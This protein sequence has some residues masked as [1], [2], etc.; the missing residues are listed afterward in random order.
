[1]SLHVPTPLLRLREGD[2]VRLCGLGAAARGLALFSSVKIW[3]GARDGARLSAEI[4]GG[5]GVEGRVQVALALDTHENEAS[6][7]NGRW[8]CS[9]HA[10]TDTS[11]VAVLACEHVAA[12]LT[13]WIRTPDIFRDISPRTPETPPVVVDL[14][15]AA[16][17]AEATAASA[18]QTT[19]PM[20]PSTLSAAVAHMSIDAV[21][22]ALAV[23]EEP[24][25]SAALRSPDS[26]G[27]AR[28]RLLRTL[29]DPATL[30]RCIGRLD[31]SARAVLTIG[32]LHGGTLT[33]ADLE[34]YAAR[35]ALTRGALSPVLGMLE[36]MCLLLPVEGVAGR[37]PAQEQQ[38]HQGQEGRAGLRSAFTGWRI[39]RE[40]L[41]LL[42]RVALLA[43]AAQAALPDDVHV[44]RPG[45]RPLALALA[46]LAAAP[47]PRLSAASPSARSRSTVLTPGD[48][49][50]AQV[51]ERSRMTGVA[52][53]I[54]RL[55]WRVLHRAGQTEAA[56]Q[57]DRLAQ[58]PPDARPAA[59]RAAFALWRAAAVPYEL[60]DLDASSA[61]LCVRL[62]LDAPH[63]SVE[64]LASE[65]AQARQAVVRLI[66]LLSPGIWYDVDAL[67]DLLWRAHPLFLRGRQQTYTLPAW[68]FEQPRE[69]RILRPGTRRDWEQ[70]EGLFFRHLLAGP[71]AWFGILNLARQPGGPARAVRVTAFGATCL[72]ETPLQGAS[73]NVEQDVSPEDVSSLDGGWGVPVL[74]RSGGTLA[75]Q[76]FAA[77]APLLGALARWARGTGVAD[78]RLLYALTAEVAADAFDAGQQFEPFV[79]L[80][81]GSDVAHGPEVA[82]FVGGQ[83]AGWRS[84][85]GNTTIAL[86]WVLLSGA[87]EATLREA[88]A[89][90]PDL[91]AR[92]QRLSPTDVLVPEADVP[93]LSA[94]LTRRGYAL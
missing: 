66:S 78:G 57:V 84:A 71:L 63:F 24:A 45:P 87:D 41:P 17:T 35:S 61:P 91:D 26:A 3:N 54:V 77:G 20:A 30:S 85:Y 44:E 18:S 83:L 33:Q 13:A 11:T 2:V 19:P 7:P 62:R 4:G 15:G 65:V 21:R 16:R 22:E 79:A 6:P 50:S 76:P 86:G 90:V 92:C 74:L 27:E 1:M 31:A 5:V 49:S 67:V 59:L 12:L 43:E 32:L 38:G 8:R 68:T 70:A 14:H 48:L 60:A 88:L 89:Y 9:Q 34:G 82:E 51:A 75:V 23:A 94:A 10:S 64:A 28:R 53:G 42:P 47:A 69:G 40:V 46:L 93:E 39:P 56:A 37:L 36:R 73:P 29:L 72:E 80:L 58:L 52:P 81:R 55:A 25:L